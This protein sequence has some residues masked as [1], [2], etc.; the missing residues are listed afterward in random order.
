MEKNK[1]IRLFFIFLAIVS[2]LLA[3]YLISFPKKI[4]LDLSRFP[5]KLVSLSFS[6][7]EGII[8]CH[9]SLREVSILK[10]KNQELRILLMKL[11]EEERENKRLKELLAFKKSSNLNLVAAKVISFDASNFR[12][13]VTIDKGKI[14]GI[15]VGNPTP[16]IF[17]INKRLS[18]LDNRAC[19]RF[20]DYGQLDL[21]SD[22]MWIVCLAN[23]SRYS[24]SEKI[25]YPTN[26]STN[27]R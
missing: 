7:I 26:I 10:K 25:W 17:F 2:F 23:E 13:S 22:T 14:S 11:Q 18:L 15:R 9:K 27:N 6:P 4:T 16:Y 24:I 1:A 20:I 5:L 3:S 12:K 21:L 19:K 8:N